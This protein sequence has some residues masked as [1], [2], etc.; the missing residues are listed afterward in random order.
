MKYNTMIADILQELIS[1]PVVH[2]KEVFPV[3]N[4]SMLFDMKDGMKMR[5][6][7]AGFQQIKYELYNFSHNGIILNA[8]P[9][10]NSGY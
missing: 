1:L 9:T 4:I 2:R 6:E 10:Q 8:C 3:N 7:L 5:Y